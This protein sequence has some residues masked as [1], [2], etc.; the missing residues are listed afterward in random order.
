M[1]S[2]APGCTG[3]TESEGGAV[4]VLLASPWMDCPPASVAGLLFASV[5]IGARSCASSGIGV[6]GGRGCLIADTSSRSISL[7]SRSQKQIHSCSNEEIPLTREILRRVFCTCQLLGQCTFDGF[8][9]RKGAHSYR[10]DRSISIAFSTKARSFP[11]LTARPNRL[12]PNMF[13]IKTI[14]PMNSTP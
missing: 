8:E 10:N 7:G 4:L 12:S 14:P 11:E 3:T 5:G 13:V 9:G 6:P 2:V 1:W